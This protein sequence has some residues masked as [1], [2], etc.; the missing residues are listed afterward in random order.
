MEGRDPQLAPRILARLRGTRVRLPCPSPTLSP[1]SWRAPSGRL[2]SVPRSLPTA[3][4]PGPGPAAADQAA[5]WSPAPACAR[6]LSL[7]GVGTRVWRG[8]AESEVRGDSVRSCQR[9][10]ERPP[11]RRAPLVAP[12][13]G[14]TWCWPLF[15]ALVG[16]TWGRRPRSRVLNGVERPFLSLDTAFGVCRRAC[17]RAMYL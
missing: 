3:A 13:I 14:G 9:A 12:A 17:R 2:S 10:P 6:A 4:R 11:P 8:L 15:I 7:R 5:P 1:A 16:A